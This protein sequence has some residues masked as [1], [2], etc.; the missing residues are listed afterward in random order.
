MNP[1]DLPDP[2]EATLNFISDVSP[3]PHPRSAEQGI[4]DM[5]Q[6]IRMLRQQLVTFL[7]AAVSDQL[8]AETRKEIQDAEARLQEYRTQLKGRN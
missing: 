1:Q 5:E 6:Q 7:E 4:A 3:R 2:D 8:I